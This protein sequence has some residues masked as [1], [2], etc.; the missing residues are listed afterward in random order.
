MYSWN[1]RSYAWGKRNFLDQSTSKVVPNEVRWIHKVSELVTDEI[2]FNNQYN[3]SLPLEKLLKKELDEV[4]CGRTRR[5]FKYWS[6]IIFFRYKCLILFD[7]III[8][9]YEFFSMTL[10]QSLSLNRLETKCKNIVF[11]H[12]VDESFDPPSFLYRM[13]NFIKETG[14]PRTRFTNRV[15]P[16]QRTCRA[17]ISLIRTTLEPLIQNMF[18]TKDSPLR[19]LSLYQSS[20]ASLIE[21]SNNRDVIVC[22][23]VCVSNKSSKLNLVFETTIAFQNRSCYQRSWS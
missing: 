21:S 9:M 5:F 18:K 7:F 1:A 11:I 6:N 13:F 14:T 12:S 10:L 4:R 17:E 15:I 8:R 2:S 19:V 3:R 16:V 20:S 23:C 22:D